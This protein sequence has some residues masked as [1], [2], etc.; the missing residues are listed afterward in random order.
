M[1][2]P[3]TA[4]QKFGGHDLRGRCSRNDSTCHSG[5]SGVEGRKQLHSVRL[6]QIHKQIKHFLKQFRRQFLK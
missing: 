4:V 1:I 3:E 6:C 2:G 5:A